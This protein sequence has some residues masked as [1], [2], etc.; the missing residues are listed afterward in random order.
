MSAPTSRARA[1]PRAAHIQALLAAT[2]FASAVV[3]TVNAVEWVAEWFYD[4]SWWSYIVLVDALVHLRRGE[5]L[6]LSRPRAFF[7]LA[8]FSAAFW[9]FFEL[10][11]FR[12]ENW[13]YVG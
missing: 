6:L 11:N 10:V 1:R 13:Y 4:L 7:L 2:V 9:L 8:L 12:L 3:G 5:S